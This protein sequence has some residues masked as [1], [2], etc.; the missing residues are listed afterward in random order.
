MAAPRGVQRADP[1]ELVLSFLLPDEAAVNAN[2]ITSFCHYV[3]FFHSAQAAQP[4]LAE[5]KDAF[6]LSVSEAY[7]LG[8]Q[9][10]H[11]RYGESLLQEVAMAISRAADQRIST[12]RRRRRHVSR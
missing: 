8:R 12:S 11:A 2:V 1:A 3:H 4:W 7:E 9:I 5:R 10:N 6:L